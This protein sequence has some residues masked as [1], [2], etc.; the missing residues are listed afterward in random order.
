MAKKN[1]KPVAKTPAKVKKAAILRKT[2]KLAEPKSNVKVLEGKSNKQRQKIMNAQ[3]TNFQCLNRN[4]Q[5]INW[6]CR[7]GEM[8][9]II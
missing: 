9:N 7:G 5:V 8:K 6:T 2:E 3:R 4:L 1:V